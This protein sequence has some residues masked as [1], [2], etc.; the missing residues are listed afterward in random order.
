MCYYM[1]VRKN[2]RKEPEMTTSE[3]KNILSGNFSDKADREYW[4]KKLAEAE[5]KERNA[6]E[7]ETYLR[8]MS[9]YDR[10]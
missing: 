7:N 3:I 10:L 8:K 2:D 6:K 4:E 5:R 1:H 9:K